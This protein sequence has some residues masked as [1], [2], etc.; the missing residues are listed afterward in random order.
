MCVYCT[1][2]KPNLRFLPARKPFYLY[3]SPAIINGNF[4]LSVAQIKNLVY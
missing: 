1:Y 4:T 3:S 2:A